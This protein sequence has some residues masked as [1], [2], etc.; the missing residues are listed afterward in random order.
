M[1]TRQYRVQSGFALLIFVVVLMGIGGIALTGFA[2]K[3]IKE[4]QKAR[5]NHNKQILE[6]A[7]HALLMYAYNY[8]DASGIY[9]VWPCRATAAS[10][11][12]NMIT[13]KVM[14]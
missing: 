7:K 8:P 3:S 9:W 10:T 2:Q 12:V 11:I 13:K 4:V 5:F 14:L 1:E 6:S